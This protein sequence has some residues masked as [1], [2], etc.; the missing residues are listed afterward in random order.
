MPCRFGIDKL[1]GHIVR[2]R[3]KIK[4][5]PATGSTSRERLAFALN[6]KKKAPAGAAQL[7]FTGRDTG[8]NTH[9]A[10]LTVV[11]Q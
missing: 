5:S 8:D 10:T 7:V 3:R 9:T 1:P 6:V 11:V 4:G 2:I